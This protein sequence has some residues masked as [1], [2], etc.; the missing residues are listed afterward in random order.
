MKRILIV[1]ITSLGDMVF[2]QPLVADL[3][4]AFPGVRID[5]IADE[6]CADVP[7][8]NADIDR[9]ISPPLRRYKQMRE[10]S[11]LRAIFRALRELR[12][13]KYDAVI[14]VHGVY[15]S[16]IV[17]FL[18]RARHRFGFPTNELGERGAAFAYT[19]I[20]EPSAAPHL[21][22]ARH[23]IRLC[24]SKA[25]GYPLHADPDYGLRVPPG[26]PAFAAG[27]P[28][29]V[30]FHGTSCETKKWPRENWVSVGRELSGR[31]L[32]LLI[33]WGSQAEREEAEAIAAGIPG[34]MLAPRTSVT[35]WARVVNHATLVIGTDTGLVHIADALRRPAVMIFTRT[36]REHF[37]IDAP[38]RSVS[39]GG[40]GVIP[41]VSEVIDAIDSVLPSVSPACEAV[42]A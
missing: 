33:A 16:A 25:L 27:R 31:G 15:K 28:F 36:S 29:A 14:D 8:W 7:R 24:V 1:K 26:L 9:V 18:A 13:E 12:R 4:R 20:F 22:T 3:K 32:R 10:W 40:H 38:G 37:G 23:R 42:A 17:T 11:D 5:W 41:R 30:M 2:T 34:A 21:V 39:L 19:D 6:Y 35:D